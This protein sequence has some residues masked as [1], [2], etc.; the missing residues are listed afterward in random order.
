MICAFNILNTLLCDLHISLLWV[1]HELGDHTNNKG[2]IKSIVSQINEIANK[3]PIHC[4]IDFGRMT[5]HSQFQSRHSIVNFNPD[6]YRVEYGLQSSIINLFKRST[7]YLGC[8]MKIPS[9]NCI[10]WMPRKKCN[11][12]KSMILNLSFNLSFQLR[13]YSTISSNKSSTYNT[14]KII[15]SF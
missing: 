3:F 4:R 14:I 11:G 7:A 10:T 15:L 6:F 2:K 9:Y 1:L 8:E 13:K 5:F 12:P